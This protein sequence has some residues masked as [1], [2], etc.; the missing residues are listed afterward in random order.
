[1]SKFSKT[2]NTDKDGTNILGLVFDRNLIDTQP[3]GAEDKTADIDGFVRL[4]DGE[5][6][7]LNK[8]LNY[9]LKSTS[10]IKNNK[11]SIDRKDI[12]FQIDSNVPTLMFIVDVNSKRVFWYYCPHHKDELGLAKKYKNKTIDLSDY[13]VKGNSEELK[14]KWSK[15]AVTQ[16][17][18]EAN[19]TLNNVRD[20]INRRN[21]KSALLMLEELKKKVWTNTERVIK[22]RI[23]ANMGAAHL[24]L[25]K[26]TE[27][28]QFFI[29]A[30]QYT[31]EDEK[32]L[33]NI[34]LSYLISGDLSNA[35]EFAKKTL[36]KFPENLQGIS[37]LIQAS[38]DLDRDAF[39][40][41][42][43]KNI[44]NTSEVYFALGFVELGN[45]NY[46]LSEENFRKALELDDGKSL[47]IPSALAG[48]LIEKNIPILKKLELEGL[49]KKD[50]K[51]IEEALILFAEVWKKVENTEMAEA[52]AQWL[53]SLSFGK[54]ILGR[55]DEALVDAKRAYDLAPGDGKV[56]KNLSMLFWEKG[57]FTEAYRLLEL[58]KESVD[59]PQIPYLMALAK[60]EQ[61]DFDSAISLLKERLA[62]KDLPED[63][64]EDGLGLITETFF[65]ANKKEE[66]EKY[67]ISQLKANPKNILFLIY[68]SRLYEEKN[69]NPHAVEEARKAQSFLT[70]KS[71]YHDKFMAASQLYR[72]KQF[73]AAQSLYEEIADKT[74]YS[75]LLY[76]LLY[77]YYETNSYGQALALTRLITE[78]QG[79]IEDVLKI[80]AA[81]LE[82]QGDID[83]EM[84]TYQKLVE[85]NS[86]DTATKIQIGY[87]LFRQH[88]EKEL[89]EYLDSTNFNLN[90]LSLMSRY[91]LAHLF[92]I[93]KKVKLFLDTLYETRRKFF[94][95]NQAHIEY[96]RLFF[97]R[98][99][100]TDK[101]ADPKEVA[102]GTVV[103]LKYPNGSTDYFVIDDRNDV[104]K[105]HHEIKPSDELAQ[106]LLGKKAGDKVEI[107]PRLIVEVTEV[108]SKYV[109]ALH[110][111]MAFHQSQFNNV[112]DLQSITL[113]E[114]KQK[115][116]LP[117]G[118]DVIEKQITAQYKH[119]QQV[120]ALYKNKQITI[121]AFANLVRRNLIEVW[122]G[123]VAEERLG[124]NFSRGDLQERIDAVNQLKNAKKIVIDPIALLTIHSLEVGD[125]IVKN[126]GKFG[127]TQS[128]IDL[129][130]EQMS[131][132]EPVKDKGYLTLG[133][134][135]DQLTKQEIKPESI[136]K[137]IDYL[138]RLIEWIKK[139]CE[140]L[141]I[142]RAVDLDKKQKED[143]ED[144]LGIPSLDTL[145][146]CRT[147]SHL[148][149]SDD[150]RLRAVARNDYHVD[151]IWSQALLMD[152]LAK[153]YIVQEQYDDLVVKF[154]G[155][156]YYYTSVSG[157]NL[158]FALKKAEW[159]VQEPFI[160]TLKMLEPAFSDVSSS[161]RVCVDFIYEA[162]TQKMVLGDIDE[163]IFNLL[164]SLTKGRTITEAIGLLQKELEKK[165]Y[166]LPLD[167]TRVKKIIERWSKTKVY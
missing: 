95:D 63:I 36:E 100:E 28:C 158:F 127:I 22:F 45:K 75:P 24:S 77:C 59:F 55:L 148:L 139:N 18:I 145:L 114:P 32:A 136:K 7:N 13:E 153:G 122:G 52:K 130:T 154:V 151:G 66:A 74:V 70:E 110:Q 35:R 49:V 146:I 108:K 126:Y 157:K 50:N 143:L 73:K 25:G 103:I 164:D 83:G 96:I 165:L 86:D 10:S 120:E 115:G 116:E 109:H 51:E 125:L 162:V 121:G 85:S 43:T 163:I 147:E 140:V 80:Q 138:E 33:S 92:G 160:Q 137:N 71:S 56:V 97:T 134:E 131:H 5:R 47:E 4:R 16:D 119:A 31:P 129:I 152:A 53:V 105:A 15:I 132:L 68:N 20:L 98:S 54:R 26:E 156:N 17:F 42:L 78:K 79:P 99:A 150:E 101:L 87:I 6:N 89:D 133:K 60:R 93:R 144:I 149:F 76:R 3:F 117:E 112:L 44:L 111:S 23:L 91:R 57:N 106:K 58:H 84:S 94:D 9:Q 29:D 102:N 107:D 90:N 34:A 19:T 12:D 38:D 141:P 21:P 67:I 69:D 142:E 159:K 166:L 167:Q 104:S 39:V 30:Y 82:E 14:E 61:K 1:M 41:K 65:M 11:Y 40:R 46:Q 8:F 27:A 37:I 118:F 128:T 161:V 124:I 81:I 2:G 88:K 155:L 48:L 72:L 64:K 62:E 113:G 135:G 123:M